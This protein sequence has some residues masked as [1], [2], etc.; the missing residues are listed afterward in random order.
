MPR[1]WRGDDDLVHYVEATSWLVIYCT[2]E[3][4]MQLER[5]G[6]MRSKERWPTCL[7]CVAARA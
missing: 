6:I 1:L 3:S 5:G 4:L 2:G 7:S